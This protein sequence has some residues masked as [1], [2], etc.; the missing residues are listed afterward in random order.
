MRLGVRMG[1]GCKR[2]RLGGCIAY[3]PAVDVEAFLHELSADP[4][5][6]LVFPGFTAFVKETSPIN[7][8]ASIKM[9]VL[10]F[11]AKD[12][13]KAPYATA[14]RF[15]EKLRQTNPRVTFITE[16]T[17]DHYEPMIEK[18]I[19]AAIKWIQSTPAAAEP[20]ELQ[21]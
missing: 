5:A 11:Q 16:E 13:S 15:V 9:P 7:T 21:R 19:P 17:G 18:G 1:E 12:D 10:L 20:P 8:T 6:N 4:A 3:A 2:I 14:N